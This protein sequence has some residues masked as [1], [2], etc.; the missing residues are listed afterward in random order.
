MIRKNVQKII[1]SIMVMFPAMTS[2][3]TGA[4]CNGLDCS[5]KQFVWY[6]TEI[7]FKPVFILIISLTVVMFLWGT[8]E[9]IGLASSDKRAE[10][11]K[12][13][14][15][16]LIALAVLMCFWGLARILRYTFFP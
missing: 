15:V 1:G 12:K 11:R 10:G 16:G 7:L 9:Y 14:L 2:A 3:Q 6:V 4:W 13:M 5:F 8:A